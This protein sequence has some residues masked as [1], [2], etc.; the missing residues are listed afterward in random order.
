[1]HPG[2]L[3]P[4]PFSETLLFTPISFKTMWPSFTTGFKQ[5]IGFSQ[6]PK[7]AILT[8]T[9]LS[10]KHW[11]FETIKGGIERR[12]HWPG[13][14]LRQTP[15]R[16]TNPFRQLL[17]WALINPPP[18][19]VERLTWLPDKSSGGFAG[20]PTLYHIQRETILPVN[21]ENQWGFRRGWFIAEDELVW[22]K[23]MRA[24]WCLDTKLPTERP[25]QHISKLE[26]DFVYEIA[27]HQTVTGCREPCELLVRDLKVKSWTCHW[28][29]L[30]LKNSAD[31]TNA[32]HSSYRGRYCLVCPRFSG[33]SI[34]EVKFV[35][36][37]DWLKNR[38]KS[39]GLTPINNVVDIY[40]LCLPRVS[41]AAATYLRCRWDCWPKNNWWNVYQQAR[42]SQHS[43]IK[44]RTLHR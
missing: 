28:H 30:P 4:K 24:L 3:E 43:T 26:S 31:N 5:Y 35:E 19:F 21:N 40:Q 39:I 18:L 33:V 9:D 27:S 29:C 1:M 42:S 20:R 13:A 34:T 23:A 36:S 16:K 17:M 12:G 11:N 38:L 14:N 8:S 6:T 41:G 44:E 2:L 10:W 25:Q 32:R 37:P 22:A 7:S 15:E